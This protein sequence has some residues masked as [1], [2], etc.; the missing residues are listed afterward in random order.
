MNHIFL[1]VCFHVIPYIGN[2]EKITECVS[3]YAAVISIFIFDINRAI[4]FKIAH[5]SEN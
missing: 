2:L 4:Y 1:A 3:H 5:V